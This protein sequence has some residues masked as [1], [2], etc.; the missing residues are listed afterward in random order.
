MSCD[1]LLCLS[2]CGDYHAMCTV[3]ISIVI[4]NYYHLHV[5]CNISI[6]I[7][8]YS[9]VDFVNNNIING[10]VGAPHISN[11]IVENSKLYFSNHVHTY[12]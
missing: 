12:S 2:V 11:N 6:N 1:V 4:Y 7:K 8:F 3:F 9:H 10:T 5:H